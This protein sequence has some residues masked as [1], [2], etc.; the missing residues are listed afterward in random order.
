MKSK[1][2]TTALLLAFVFISL[3][4]LVLQ[5]RGA[6]NPGSTKTALDSSRLQAYYFHGKARC[7]KCIDMENYTR[8]A[9]ETGFAEEMDRKEIAFQVVNLNEPENKHFI[10]DFQLTNIS[11]ILS[12]QKGDALLEFKNLEQV[13]GFVRNKEQFM[14]YVQEET[15]AMLQGA[16]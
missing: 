7:R 12:L 3:G 8:E 2:I 5:Q 9:L 6:S 13:W 14:A 1:K 11:V 4:Y 16:H 15:R 10:E